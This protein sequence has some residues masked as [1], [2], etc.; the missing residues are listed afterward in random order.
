MQGKRGGA[1][2]A[3][4]L[5]K[6]DELYVA[7]MGD[8]R[9]MLGTRSNVVAALMSDHTS[10]REDERLYIERSVSDNHTYVNQKTIRYV[11]TRGG[12][13]SRGSGDV[14]RVQD[15]LVVSL[16]LD[17]MHEMFLVLIFFLI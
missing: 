7:N 6:D 17:M 10:N 15:S 5:V 13:I 8:C 2:A 12:Y 14:W 3:A 1:C 11:C 9:A 4:A 16:F